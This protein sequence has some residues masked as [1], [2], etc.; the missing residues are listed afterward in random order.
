MTDIC[1]K[2]LW[3]NVTF[4]AFFI[5]LASPPDSLLPLPEWHLWLFLIPP[6]SLVSLRPSVRHP[7]RQKDAKPGLVTSCLRSVSCRRGLNAPQLAL[8]VTVEV[9]GRGL[10][11]FCVVVFFYFPK[12]PSAG[13]TDARHTNT[14]T[15]RASR[16][17]GDNQD[18]C[19]GKEPV[20]LLL[21]LFCLLLLRLL[22][23]RLQPAKPAIVSGE[24]PLVFH[25]S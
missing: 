11:F 13:S 15:R 3:P 1:D 12:C 21:L 4:S 10:L 9:G 7:A 19:R 8:C 2:S 20:L 16:Q 6:L 14:G 17:G 22:L 25:L 24:G 5:C 18:S 23:Y